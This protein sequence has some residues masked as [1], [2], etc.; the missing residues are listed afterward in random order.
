ME[1][2]FECRT[3][4]VQDLSFDRSTEILSDGEDGIDIGGL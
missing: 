2:V 4:E 1:T 3:S